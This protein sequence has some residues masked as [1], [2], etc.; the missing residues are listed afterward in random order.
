MYGIFLAA[1][2]RGFAQCKI[3]FVHRTNDCLCN[4]VRWVKPQSRNACVALQDVSSL[5]LA[6]PSGAAF[7]A[8]ASL[9]RLGGQMDLRSSYAYRPAASASQMMTELAWASWETMVH[10]IPMMSQNTCSS[11]EYRCMFDEKA[12]A[13]LEAGE[14]LFSP[15]AVSAEAFLAPWHSRATAN[16][17]RL[18]D[19]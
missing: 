19:R 16:A 14:L 12:A 13:A 18:R 9:P 5:N 4:E 10:R 6:A 15:S 1:H 17:K 7:F 3:A 8:L 2:T 11:T